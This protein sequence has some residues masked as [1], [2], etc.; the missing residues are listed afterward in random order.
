LENQAIAIPDVPVE[1][2]EDG[3]IEQ[4]CSILEGGET[5]FENRKKKYQISLKSQIK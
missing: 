2:F 1:D 4:V 5:A 3:I